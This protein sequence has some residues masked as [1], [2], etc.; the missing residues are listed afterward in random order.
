VEREKKGPAPRKD[1]FLTQ[2]HLHGGNGSNAK[3]AVVSEEV[4]VNVKTPVTMMT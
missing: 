3:G 4:A 1:H 2:D